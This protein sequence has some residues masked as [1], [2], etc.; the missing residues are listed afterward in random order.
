MIVAT[1]VLVALRA[2]TSPPNP[3]EVLMSHDESPSL[4]AVTVEPS[5]AVHASVTLL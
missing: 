5:E 2:R 1:S 4:V 3:D